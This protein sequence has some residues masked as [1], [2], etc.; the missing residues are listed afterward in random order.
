MFATRR[1]GWIGI[2]IG[3]STV[4]AAQVVRSGRQLRLAAA[5]VVPRRKGWPIADLSD[6]PAISSADQIRAALSLRA[7]FRGSRVAATLPMALC[8]VHV[9]DRTFDT[10]LHQDR[11][12]RQ[13]IETATQR[14]ADHLQFDAWTVEEPDN[15]RSGRTNI[16]T[17]PQTWTDQLCED[18]ARAG[19]SCQA[20]DGLPLALARA[21]GMIQQGSHEAPAAALDWGF[22]RATFC[23]IVDSRPVYVRCLKECGFQRSL[24]AIAEHLQVTQDEAQRLLVEHGLP[25][26][27]DN[28]SIDTAK[29]LEKLLA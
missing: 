19:G 16:I 15:G 28:E 21:V 5:A 26:P 13:A 2:D 27:T 25:G 20:I 1:T 22:G 10:E 6:Q 29:V 17:A 11:I 14:S 9:L 3:T 23:L 4:K 24:E 8:D 18:I 7:D 12:I